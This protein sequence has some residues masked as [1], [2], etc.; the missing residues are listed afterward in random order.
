MKKLMGIFGLAMLL[1]LCSASLT[2]ADGLD[3]FTYTAGGNTF[4]WQLPSSPAPAVA[5]VYPG[6]GFTLNNVLVSENGGTP[7]LAS[8]D[9]YSTWSAGGFD[10]TVGNN[11]LAN[12]A[13]QQLYQGW[14]GA[15]TFLTG[16]FL[17]TDYAANEDTFPG[18][19]D[20][21]TNVPEPSALGLL[22]VGVLILFLGLA[23][24]KAIGMPVKI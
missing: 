10:L 21:T 3:N 6:F 13:W 14:E 23:S 18:T 24:R 19:L 4:T 2:K 16:T 22:A 1:A 12:T 9:F 17:L 11:M 5:D 15:P 20:I 7:V 8:F